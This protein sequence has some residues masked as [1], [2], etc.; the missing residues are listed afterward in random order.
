MKRYGRTV[1]LRDDPAVFAQY[2]AYHAQP[3]PEVT[4]GVQGSGVLRLYIYRFGRQLFMFM[5][6]TDDYDPNRLYG[7]P[8]PARAQEWDDLMRSFQV[9]VPGAPPD[10]TWVDMKEVYEFKPLA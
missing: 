8:V 3:W 5:E 6:T 4:A 2:D 7:D 10:G 9:P 1:N